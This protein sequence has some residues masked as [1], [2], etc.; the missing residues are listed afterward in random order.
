MIL[1][2]RRVLDAAPQINGCH[3]SVGSGARLGNLKHTTISSYW[4]SLRGMVLPQ[5]FQQRHNAFAVPGASQ[6]LRHAHGICHIPMF[7]PFSIGLHSHSLLHGSQKFGFWVTFSPP[8][9]STARSSSNL[10]HRRTDDLWPII[11]PA[12]ASNLTVVIQSQRV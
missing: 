3:L 9:H 7:G 8:R 12:D 4:P 6:E 2:R 5:L 10:F 11:V 1:A